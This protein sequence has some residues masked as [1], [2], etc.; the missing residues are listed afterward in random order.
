MKS[1]RE[2]ELK[3]FD[4]K[5]ER[6]YM[7]Y[8]YNWAW[9]KLESYFRQRQLGRQGQT[10]W[11]EAYPSTRAAFDSLNLGQGL[12]PSQDK[13]QI[14]V[15]SLLD[16]DYPSLLKEIKDPPG[17][18]YLLGRDLDYK[19]GLTVSL[20]GSRRPTPYG[21]KV[22]NLIV[23]Y[24]SHPDVTIISGMAIG[25]DSI[26]QKAALKEGMNSVAVLGSGVD[27]CYPRSQSK[28]Y[29]D[30]ISRGSIVSEF[31]PGTP[32]KAY[33][34]PLRNRI[35]SGL[36]KRLVVAE[37]GLKSG[38][39]LTARSALEQGRDVYAVPGSIFM[40]NSQGCHRL[41]ND[42]AKILMDLDDLSE[43]AAEQVCD[44][45][46]GDRRWL[47][48]IGQFEPDFLSLQAILKLGTSELLVGLAKLEGR[49]LI[50]QKNARYLLTSQALKLIST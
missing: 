18:L 30:L 23:Q 50:S 10:A 47:E 22:A 49:G 37:A 19:E 21:E 26:A 36:S 28:L 2:T 29:R 16:P 24:F 11:L 14:R 40:Q 7:A 15:L 27:V 12:E 5:R 39:M 45:S 33:H 34:F 35:I 31:P 20:V 13:Q 8:L 41:I 42:G 3:R 44:L 43:V 1:T 46:P 6:V 4:H 17:I 32:A 48:V 25:I 38:T 9:V